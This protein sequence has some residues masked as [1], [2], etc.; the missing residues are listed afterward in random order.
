MGKDMTED[1]LA[2]GCPVCNHIEEGLLSFF[3]RWQHELGAKEEARDLF[4][5]EGGFCPGHLWQLAA[6]SS[7]RGLAYGLQPLLSRLADALPL[8]STG[9]PKPA[10]ASRGTCRVCRLLRDEERGYVSRLARFL[11][12]EEGRAVYGDAQGVCLRHLE[13]LMPL[14]ADGSAS[15]LLRQ[16][17]CRCKEIEAA[18][19][20][21][22]EKL[23]SLRR[24]DC[25]SFEKEAYRR[26]LVLLAGARSISHLP[27]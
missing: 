6:F 16:A 9:G 27:C 2:W 25:T 20:S 18:L 24:R 14:V 23:N 5:R 15:F 26:A 11:D 7:P 1:L 22:R 4:A 17:A 21:Y 10:A 8:M 13:M 19:A 12:T 3:A